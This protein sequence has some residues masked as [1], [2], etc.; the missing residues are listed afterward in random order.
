[1]VTQGKFRSTE[2]LD[3]CESLLKITVKCITT[4]MSTDF[5]KIGLTM[6]SN[7]GITFLCKKT[8]CE[9]CQLFQLP[10]PAWHRKSMTQE[11]NRIKMY[12]FVAIVFSVD[13][14]AVYV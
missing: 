5:R 12:T 4:F 2:K 9:S 6:S 10:L 11:T 1:M 13:P 7:Q 14:C 8:L 3:T